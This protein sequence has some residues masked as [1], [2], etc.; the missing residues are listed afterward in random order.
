MH[1]QDIIQFWFHELSDKQRFA[2]D[3]AL[4]AKIRQRFGS[5]LQAAVLGEL[6]GWRLTPQ[7]RLAEIVVLDQFSRNI[8]RDSR[9]AFAQDPQALALAQELVASGQDQNLSAE[10]RSFAYMPYMH[11]ES[12]LVH[13]EA[14]RLFAQPGMEAS[15]VFEMRHKAI[16]ERFGRYLHRNAVLGRPSTAAEQAF[17][18][19][20][21]SSF[22]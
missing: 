15:L 11:S 12:L 20:P 18:A 17:L 4:D 5:T 6:F 10:Q 7:G 1:A 16:I 3:L 9:E 21:D 8:Y 22:Y 2:K 19:E 14:V 13:D